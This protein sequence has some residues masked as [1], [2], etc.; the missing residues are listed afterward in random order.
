MMDVLE[1]PL[2]IID[3]ETTGTN[4]FRHDVLA[5]G[6]VPISLNLPTATVYVRHQQ[7]VWTDFAR[8][9]FANYQAEW[10]ANAVSAT[11][12]CDRI[13][14]YLADT[15]GGQEVTPVGHNIGF[16]LAFMKKLAFL[17]GRER[18]ALL[19]HR[20]IDTHTLLYLMHLQGFL[21]DEA[22]TS[23]GAF[24][25]FGIHVEERLRH[26][27]VADAKAT[28]ELLLHLLSMISASTRRDRVVKLRRNE[29]G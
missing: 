22:V 24:R 5:V 27:A 8:E 17:G 1:K 15:F 6:L 13:E 16:D 4:P 25:H 28:R 18:V 26:T 23:D 12:A 9:I 7:C 20:A 11:E 2:I 14:K 10:Q 19:S 29:A 21:P 3:L